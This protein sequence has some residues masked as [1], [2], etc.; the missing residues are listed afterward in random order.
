MP[1]NVYF[2][3]EGIRCPV[4][5]APEIQQNAVWRMGNQNVHQIVC[6][7]GHSFRVYE[8]ENGSY[9]IVLYR[10]SSHRDTTTATATA[11]QTVEKT[12]RWA[13]A[14][15][16][17][18]SLDELKTF[19]THLKA[20]IE[21]ELDYKEDAHA[22]IDNKTS[23]FFGMYIMRYHEVPSCP[24]CGRSNCWIHIPPKLVRAIQK[25]ASING[26][27][28]LIYGSA[29]GSEDFATQLKPVIDFL[30]QHYKVTERDSAHVHLLLTDDYTPLPVTVANNYWQLV[31]YFY[32]GYAWVFGNIQGS[33]LR[34][35]GYSG[36]Q[37]LLSS[38]LFDRVGGNRNAVYF[39]ESY[40]QRNKI[41]IFNIEN[42]LADASLNLKQLVALRAVN[43]ALMKRAAELS[44]VGLIKV[45]NDK[46]PIYKGLGQIINDLVWSNISPQQV[47]MNLVKQWM[48]R[49][50]EEMLDEI[51]HLLS[52]F[53]YEIIKELIENPPREAQ[54][55][56][57][58][59]ISLPTKRM[60]R[61][62]IQAIL[63]APTTKTE[64]ESITVIAKALG[65]TEE[66]VKKELEKLG[67]KWCNGKFKVVA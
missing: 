19:M 6:Q 41:I 4:C 22:E 16:P 53:E 12:G 51:K 64:K 60:D 40:I 48:K 50:A 67:A 57:N 59:E 42:R 1:D 7:N 3:I 8:H 56:T 26:N 17:T 45:D 43:L 66:K 62:L 20:G 63:N 29:E 25:D 27:E 37:D 58:V 14:E 9:R 33:F 44:L 39:G 52:P 47:D 10:K 32:P 38:P 30:S 18:L 2:I 11:T 13:F 21:L 65:K 31:R 5:G 54:N 61:T 34:K 36:F 15:A 46:W 24:V 55:I 49:N 35:S 28:F 23:D